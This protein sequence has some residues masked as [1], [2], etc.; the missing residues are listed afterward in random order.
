[1]E[2]TEPSQNTFNYADVETTYLMCF[3]VHCVPPG[4]VSSQRNLTQVWFLSLTRQEEGDC[5]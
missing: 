4:S 2:V 5:N 3:R 1:M